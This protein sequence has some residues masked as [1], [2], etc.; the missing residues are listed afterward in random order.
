MAGSAGLGNRTYVGLNFETAWATKNTDLT[1]YDGD[2]GL[3]PWID[4]NSVTLPVEERPLRSSSLTGIAP[5]YNKIAQGPRGITGDVVW[6]PNYDC[7]TIQRLFYL[8]MGHYFPFGPIETQYRPS[9]TLPACTL[10]SHVD[11]QALRYYGGSLSQLRGSVSPDSFFDLT[12]SFIFKDFDEIDY[13]SWDTRAFDGEERDTL[14]RSDHLS[15][16]RYDTS[17]TSGGVLIDIAAVRD[18]E[19]FID[20]RLN[21]DRRVLGSRLIKEPD[22]TDRFATGGRAVLEFDDSTMFYQFY[23]QYVGQMLFTFVGGATTGSSTN[24]YELRLDW[25]RARLSAGSP[26]VNAFGII[27][28]EVEW[29]GLR[30]VDGNQV[31]DPSLIVTVAND[32]QL[33]AAAQ[34]T[35]AEVW[36]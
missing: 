23:N 12:A 34:P 17:G 30:G 19:F 28:L 22:R 31:T 1:Q 21:P 35:P 10:E 29:E 5:L 15:V 4:V 32:S 14:I 33:T 2:T 25:P 18:F 7:E 9:A 26:T 8:A 13:V 16:A 20:N 11:K 24:G 3:N 36:T 27:T 6:T